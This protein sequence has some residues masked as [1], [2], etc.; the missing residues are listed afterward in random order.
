MWWV[1]SV[2][3]VYGYSPWKL[4]QQRKQQEELDGLTEQADELFAG[5]QEDEE[6]RLVLVFGYIYIR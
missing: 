2:S 1:A 5:E 4:Y 6:F 3:T